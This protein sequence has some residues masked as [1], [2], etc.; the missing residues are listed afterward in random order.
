[1]KIITIKQPWAH[2]IAEGFKDIENRAWKT[3]FRGKLGIHVGKSM[4]DINDSLIVKLIER[5][6]IPL[7]SIESLK[8][9]QGFI[10]ATVDLTRIERDSTNFWAIPGQFHWKLESP[11]KIEPVAAIGKLGLWNFDLDLELT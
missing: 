1:M 6:H 11:Q 10:I 3:D 5:E 7:P 8:N 9:Q 4:T 2:L